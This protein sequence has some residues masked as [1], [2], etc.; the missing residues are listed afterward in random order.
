[1]NRNVIYVVCIVFGSVSIIG[2]S[3]V[4]LADKV[5]RYKAEKKP[6]TEVPAPDYRELAKFRTTDESVRLLAIE[7]QGL[8]YL[9]VSNGAGIAVTPMSSTMKAPSDV[10]RV[11]TTVH[12]LEDYGQ[13]LRYDAYNDEDLQCRVIMY[14]Y[15]N[16]K[17]T[18]LVYDCRGDVKATASWDTVPNDNVAY[19]KELYFLHRKFFH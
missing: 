15:Y 9:I 5:S 6:T 2:L 1:M 3:A 4:F 8:Q 13:V 14:Y 10:V 16:E 17:Q 12:Y 11:D 19:L 7:L 18:N